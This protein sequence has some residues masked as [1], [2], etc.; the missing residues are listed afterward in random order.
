M[1]KFLLIFLIPVFLYSENTDWNDLM[2]K[3]ASGNIQNSSSTSSVSVS[4]NSNGKS[5]SYSTK[6][7]GLA[8]NGLTLD[9]SSMSID[10]KI[11]KYEGILN[12]L[13]FIRDI[14]P[15]IENTVNVNFSNEPLQACISTIEEKLGVSI[16]ATA[17]IDSVVES[18]VAKNIK[19]ID[20]LEML[21]DSSKTVL[22]FSRTCIT[23]SEIK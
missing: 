19:A 17:P 21:A 10:D 3:V 11:K 15:K 13:Y 23:F 9:D 7:S 16:Y 4:I 1:N 5:S 22:S 20:L 2:K 6:S 8:F 14:C 12:K 18:V